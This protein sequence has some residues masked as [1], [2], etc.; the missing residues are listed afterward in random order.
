MNKKIKDIEVNGEKVVKSRKNID[1][2]AFAIVT[3]AILCG[4]KIIGVIQISWWWISSPMILI[5]F[6]IFIVALT[7]FVIWIESK[8]K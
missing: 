8:E 3:C 7:G 2:I 4:L 6:I 1:W 5:A